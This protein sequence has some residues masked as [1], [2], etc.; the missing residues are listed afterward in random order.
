MCLRLPAGLLAVSLILL[1]AP[2]PG[3]GDGLAPL[4]P[5]MVTDRA[6]EKARYLELEGKLQVA[7]RT[8][9]GQCGETV[10]PHAA[11]LGGVLFERAGRTDEARRCYLRT[12]EA[13]HPLGPRAAW[14]LSL[15]DPPRDG[16]PGSGSVWLTRAT[17]PGLAGRVAR[18]QARHLMDAGQNRVAA[19]VLTRG[20]AAPLSPPE[21][22]EIRFLLARCHLAY[23]D[24]D[25]GLAILTRLAWEG[26]GPADV[27]LRAEAPAAALDLLDLRR[28][29]RASPQ[30]AVSRR[31]AGDP[32]TWTADQQFWEGLALLLRRRD[33]EPALARLLAAREAGVGTVRI[34]ATWHAARALEKLDRDL[35][36]MELL[37]ELLGEGSLPFATEIRV[38]LGRL[39]LREELPFRARGYLE[40]ALGDALPGEDLAE[41]AWT[42][43]RFH[44]A[45][46]DPAGAL[47]LL[48]LIRRRSFVVARSPWQ[49]WGPLALYWEA[50]TLEDLGQGARARGLYTLLREAAPL[51]Y[52]GV[53][54][55][56]RLTG[57]GVETNPPG[58]ARW[59]APPLDPGPFDAGDR[60]VLALPLALWRLGLYDE[61]REETVALLRSGA[62]S[63]GL[64]ALHVSL[65][66]RG[67]RL[68]RAASLRR[69][70]GTLL[71]PPWR[72]GARLWLPSLPVAY[73]DRLGPV[74]AD[75]GGG[76]D[77]A[78][79]AALIK[80][81][82]SW[83]PTS[84]SGADAHGL[85][86]L[87]PYVA[88]Q[89]AER[90]MGRRW[91]R[92]DLRDPEL[93]L[94]IG[95]QF[96]RE[97]LHRHHGNWL[98]TLA[99]FNA[100]TGTA[101]SWLT[102]FAGL[103][104]DAWVEQITY[105]NTVGY[106]K[107]ILGAAVGY[108]SLYWPVLGRGEVSEGVAFRIPPDLN[109]YLDEAGGRCAPDAA[110]GGEQ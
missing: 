71:P 29:V 96:L 31:P 72:S 109:P 1:I 45:A 100:G 74:M 26:H 78:V 41:A 77:P 52:Y 76:M 94:R 92:G 24:R 18:A 80:F 108:R 62:L 89:V 93:N 21:R 46:G 39:C 82:S 47:G 81:E 37:D 85:M 25:R 95:A 17:T 19:S 11:Y 13:D 66:L 6:F 42:L 14:R 63:P 32:A 48:R 4:Q 16:K 43:A 9:A 3:V 87:R 79:I 69:D 53:L 10:A 103:D 30:D 15:L 57:S 40:R 58:P 49:T 73:L 86:Q 7:A 54:A 2:A 90:C 35:D 88:R 12:A 91:R 59:S 102:R 56:A 23:G 22:L 27:A 104:A 97:V 5:W 60:V 83:N 98:V 107:R 101:R 61:A 38:R 106:V 99:A 20:L 67:E 51:N 33:R 55:R 8:V 64:P 50:R 36:A 28:R 75:D 110:E 44:R 84:V 105:P 68:A 34:A 70:I 65:A